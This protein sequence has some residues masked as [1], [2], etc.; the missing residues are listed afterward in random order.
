MA[1]SKLL[2]GQA[3]PSLTLRLASGGEACIGAVAPG[4]AA[5]L[6]VLYRGAFCPFCKARAGCP[7]AMA[8]RKVHQALTARRGGACGVCAEPAAQVAPPHLRGPAGPQPPRS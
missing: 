6:V 5:K 2:P 4:R 3:L 8:A 1:S 7:A